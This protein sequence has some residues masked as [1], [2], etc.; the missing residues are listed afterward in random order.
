MPGNDAEGAPRQGLVL[1]LLVAA[2]VVVHLPAYS[3]WLPALSRWYVAGILLTFSLQ[4]IVP[5][6]LA[7]MAPGT[8]D[9]DLQWLP[10]ARSQWAWFLAMVF[11]LF[12]CAGL[13]IWLANSLGLGSQPLLRLSPELTTLATAVVNAVT[14][15]LVGPICEEIF[16]RA[17]CL[18]QLRK[19]TPSGVA[20]LIHSLLFALNH[21]HHG[22][23][24][25]L[26]AFLLG[27]VFGAWRIRFRSLL[28]LILA[29]V[30]LNVGPG[31]HCLQV[32]WY[33]AEVMSKP[34]CREID[35]LTK[36][37][38][39]KAIPSIIRFF[40]DP[41]IDVRVYAQVTLHV[42]YRDAAEPYLKE[43]LASS[44]KTILEGVLFAIERGGYSGLREEV[45]RL[46]WSAH[47]V[48][49]QMGA[50]DTLSRLGDAE[51][52]RRIAQEHPN[53]AVRQIAGTGLAAMEGE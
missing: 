35:L 50:T 21:L 36:Q 53:E 13:A 12:V 4:A 38:T 15:I 31:I 14:L 18:E 6:L 20:L 34:R 2:I 23:Q 47:D 41:D 5:F 33:A 28:P 7:R 26:S 30:V 42:K 29:H 16:W 9:F 32:E 51:G 25:S 45:R 1:G 17:Y 43:A 8:A 11:L 19:L 44:N 37:P 52:L 22:L 46:V 49:I 24:T 27:T 10:D 39:E 40:A 3:V 48:D